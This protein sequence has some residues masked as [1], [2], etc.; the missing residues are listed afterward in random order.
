MDGNKVVTV[1]EDEVRFSLSCKF[2]IFRNQQEADNHRD[3]T[4]K[5]S[6]T[7]IFETLTKDLEKRGII[8]T[9][10]K[11]DLFD[12]APIF[13]KVYILPLSPSSETIESVWREYERTG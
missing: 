9:G 5:L 8:E 6:A 1:R 7:Q 4:R 2:H 12:L 13:V 10:S 11:M 3:K